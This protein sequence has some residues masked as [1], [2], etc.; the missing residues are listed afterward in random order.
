M[1]SP[2]IFKLAHSNRA[3]ELRNA[4]AKGYDPNTPHVR[5]GTLLLQI[6][7]SS[8]AI[9]AVR[10]LLD[11]GADP[12]RYFTRVSPV[13]GR[14]FKDHYP[15]MS[16]RSVKVAE[17]MIAAGARLDLRDQFGWT[18]LVCAVHAGEIDLC[19]FYL[20]HGA[21]TDVRLTWHGADMTLMEFIDGCTRFYS[22]ADPSVGDKTR[23]MVE[24]L[25]RIKALVA[26]HTEARDAS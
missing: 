1:N 19:A 6:A 8:D 22:A 18:P 11:A 2:D 3:D 21:R 15:M 17:V 26:A 25:T 20:E 7:C 23:P 5:A 4:M 16:V 24:K 14:L 9:D 12:N 13:D 10:V